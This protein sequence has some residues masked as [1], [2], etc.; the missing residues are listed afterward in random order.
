MRETPGGIKKSHFRRNSGFQT[1]DFDFR[2]TFILLT[3]PLGKASHEG[4]Y[5]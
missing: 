4:R 1:L 3:S 2:Q 5:L